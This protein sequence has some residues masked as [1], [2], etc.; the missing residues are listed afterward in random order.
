M[1][2]KVLLQPT[3]EVMDLGAKQW[4]NALLGNFLGKSPLL[5]VFQRTTDK[6]WGREGSVFIHFLASSV[7]LINF[8]SQRVRNWVLESGPW[9]IQQKAL[10]MRK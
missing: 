2:G 3:R 4:D 1:N 5:G 9:H 8:P 6:L 7:Y 10:I